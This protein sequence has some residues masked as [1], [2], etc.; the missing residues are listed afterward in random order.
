MKRE[1]K[2]IEHIYN[3]RPQ[4]NQLLGEMLVNDILQTA[5]E[6]SMIK[7]AIMDKEITNLEVK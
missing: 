4:L 7:A 5:K 6:L 3:T 2:I 1:E